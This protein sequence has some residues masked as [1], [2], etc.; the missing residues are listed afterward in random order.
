MSFSFSFSFSFLLLTLRLLLFVRSFVLLLLLLTQLAAENY[1]L[2]SR[3]QL[4]QLAREVQ[5]LRRIL[6]E[7]KTRDDQR[8]RLAFV[9]QEQKCVFF[10]R[11]FAFCSALLLFSYSSRSLVP[12]HLSHPRRVV[13]DGDRQ[14]LTQLKRQLNALRAADK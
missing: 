5:R 13:L 8:L 7:H 14:R 2:R 3:Q 6:Q 12:H 11:F 10:C 1:N 4:Q 9:A